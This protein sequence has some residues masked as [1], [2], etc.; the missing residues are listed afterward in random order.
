M[1]RI[2]AVLLLIAFTSA[3]AAQ[4]KVTLRLD[5]VNSGYHAIWYYAIDK[6]L[7]KAEGIDLDV[8]E[9][10]GSAVVA[11]TVGNGS[12]MF[13]TSDTG[14][15]MGLASQGL[16]VKIVGG[17]LRQ[18]PFA[19]I[20]PKKNNWSSY[21][22]LQKGNPRIGMSPGSGAA[23]LLPAVIKAA[24][25]QDKVQLV[26]MEPAAKPTALLEGRVDAIESFDF[27]QVPLLEASGMP[28][29]TLPFAKAGIN[30]PG[31][32]LITSEDMIRKNP[33]LVKKMVHLMQQTIELGRKEPDAAIDSLLKRSPTLKREVVTQVLKLSF[34]LV[35]ADW[36]KGHPIGWMS[37][38]VMA[39]SQDVLV[40]YGQIKTKKPV[41][42]Y[43]TNEFVGDG[44]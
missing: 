32:S 28:S 22:D 26:S 2:L 31:L 34:N 9:G 10:R 44:R 39:R 8:L 11:Q 19:L 20:F 3:A 24:K 29:A 25:L 18:S 14:A 41:D 43:Y 38:E 12:V 23:I 37:P 21:A 27:L 40:E 33:A 16:P 4:E 36:S 7:F 5:W 1:S 35:D 15:V 13:G 42:S 30:V 17:Y 6:G